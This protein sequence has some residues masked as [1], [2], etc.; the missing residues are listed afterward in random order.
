MSA[1]RE[2]ILDV[3]EQVL[4]DVGAVG[5]GMGG[6]A[7]ALGIQPPSLYK[8][9]RN[10][11]D[12]VHALISRGFVRLGQALDGAVDLAAFAQVYRRQALAAPALYCLMTQHPLDRS[13][14]DPGAEECAMRALLEM[15]DENAAEHP[16][17]RAAWA[18]AHGMTALEIAGRFP[19][20]ADLDASWGVLADVSAR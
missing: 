19:P 20:G 2:Q 13:M 9:F 7:R 18:F 5:F 15:F 3:A 1:R 14:L 12:L 4:E 6:V 10:L 16:R 8:H 17:A 11:D